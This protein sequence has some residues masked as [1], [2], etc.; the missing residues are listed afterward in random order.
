MATLL[1]SLSLMFAIVAITRRRSAVSMTAL[2]VAL[3]APIAV[4]A[5][6]TGTLIAGLSDHAFTF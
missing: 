4:L 6:A 2:F 3:S 1:W 5:L